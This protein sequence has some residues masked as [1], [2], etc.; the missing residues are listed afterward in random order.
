MGIVY[1]DERIIRPDLEHNWTKEMIKEYAKCAKSVKYFALNHARAVHATKGVIPL[2]V[3]DYQMRLLDALE[4]N[5]RILGLQGRQTGKCNCFN[6][7]I[8]LRNKLTGETITTTIGDLF[9][10]ELEKIEKNQKKQ[11]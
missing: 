6:T 3:R 1:D 4:K 5:T 10:S 11:Y 9:D 2:D 8:K 7:E